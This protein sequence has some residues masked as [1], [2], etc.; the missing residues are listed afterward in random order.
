KGVRLQLN[1]FIAIV[2]FLLL[3]VA[4]LGLGLGLII[5]ALTAKYRDLVFLVS[6]GVQLLMYAT[7]VIYPLSFLKGKYKVFIL[8]NPITPLIEAFRRAILG[9]GELTGGYLLYSFA[10]TLVVLFAG[11]LI[12]NRVEK[13]FMDVI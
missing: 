3:L 13:S 11:I 10:V 7:P 4:A 5:S 2:P 1:G 12:F 6:F 8:A 9:V